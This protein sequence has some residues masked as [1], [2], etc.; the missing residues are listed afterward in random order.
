MRAVVAHLDGFDSRPLF[1]E[2]LCIVRPYFVPDVDTNLV[3]IGDD[4]P[5]LN[6]LVT[7]T[8][9]DERICRPLSEHVSAVALPATDA[10]VI[11]TSA[12]LRRHASSPP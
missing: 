6:S 2:L 9:S 5:V 7:V 10:I 12:V 1:G 8:M 3:R 11:V 4:K